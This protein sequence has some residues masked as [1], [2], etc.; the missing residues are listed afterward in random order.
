MRF[1]SVCAAGHLCEFPWKEWIGCQ[2]PGDGNLNLTD[3]GGSELTSIRIECSSLPR[4]ILRPAGKV[5]SGTTIKPDEEAGRAKLLSEAGITCPGDRPWLGDG[6]R[7][8]HAR[9]PLIGALINQTNIY[10]PRTIS[11]I[12]LPDLQEQHD[13]ITQIRNEIEQDAGTCG[14]ARTLWNMNMRR[15]GGSDSG[16]ASEEGAYA[17]DRKL[18]EQAL[19]E[20]SRDRR[21]LSVAAPQP[22]RPSR[23][24][25]LSAERSSTSSG[26]RSTTLSIFR[27]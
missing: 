13:E 1:I 2:C 7:R 5:L 15:R 9:G 4:R 3:R 11:A 8:E 25:W 24:C 20:S 6:R 16:L 26:T 17:R 27:T 21:C 19:G 10:F 23:S 12:L 18:V 22:P 14:V